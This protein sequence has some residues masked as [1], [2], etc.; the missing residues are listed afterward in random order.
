M[1]LEPPPY[2]FRD[3]LRPVQVNRYEALK[4]F[5]CVENVRMCPSQRHEC[6][7]QVCPTACLFQVISKACL[8]QVILRLNDRRLGP[9]SR[10]QKAQGA[11]T[12]DCDCWLE[13][14]SR[15]SA[16]AQIVGLGLFQIFRFWFGPKLNCD[17]EL[18]S[19][20]IGRIANCASLF[21]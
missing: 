13:F 8:F 1:I 11:Y 5:L 15:T 16:A 10:R 3:G 6:G 19:F 7:T 2:Q 20:R 9:F 18:T 14:L 12:N 17:R 21:G 4:I